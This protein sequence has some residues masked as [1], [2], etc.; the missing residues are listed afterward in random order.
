MPVDLVL[1][2]GKICIND[3]FTTAGLAV[4]E[5]KIIKIAKKTNLPSAVATIDAKECLILPGLIDV[6]THLRDQRQSY[7]EDF[8]TGTSAAAVGGITLCLDMPNNEPVT[9]DSQ[10]LKERMRVAASKLL[11]NVAF[12]SAFPKELAE[13]SRVTREGAVAFKLF[14][15]KQIGGIDIEDDKMLED[16]FL[17]AKQSVV[18]V[19]VHAEDKNMLENAS[20]QLRRANQNNIDAYLKAHSPEVEEK[21]VNRIAKII[22]KTK[23]HTHFCHI[24]SKQG[25]DA[26]LEEK[27]SGLP[28]S[29]E[30]TPHHLLLSLNHLKRY[31]TIALSDPPVRNDKNREALWSALTQGLIDIIASDHAPHLLEEKKKEIVWEVKP[32]FPS[33]ETIIP[34][35]LTQINEGRIRISDLIRL[36]AE[37]PAEIFHLKE[38]GHLAQGYFADITVVDMHQEHRVDASKFYSK[39][40]YSPFDGWKVKGK[41]IKTFVNG[42]LVMEDGEIIAKPGIG[43]IV[44]WKR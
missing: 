24:S 20:E 15:T 32:G 33:L 7:E 37:N 19:A 30:V 44:G 27:K 10:S 17:Q 1:Y 40:K 16:A 5:G 13:I 11:V 12:Y 21:A 38:R 35:L 22:E 6:H 23:T 2:N 28:L 34:L 25:L 8:F 9:M 42:C 36:M 18:P 29:C 14:L 31:G 43:K 41:P 26:V 3:S 39:A 4:E